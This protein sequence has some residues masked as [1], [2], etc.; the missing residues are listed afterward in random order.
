MH[1][2]IRRTDQRTLQTWKRASFSARPANVPCQCESVSFRAA[3]QGDLRLRWVW[4]CAREK[5]AAMAETGLMIENL[6]GGVP[7]S[8]AP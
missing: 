7:I 8:V 4:L 1:P 6:K 3:R 5:G 2:M